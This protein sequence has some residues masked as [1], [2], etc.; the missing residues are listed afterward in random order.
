ML[1]FPGKRSRSSE[2]PGF[3]CANQAE[4]SLCKCGVFETFHGPVHP[5]RYQTRFAETKSD[6]E[7][8]KWRDDNV[9]EIALQARSSGLGVE[10]EGLRA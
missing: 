6:D 3:E 7:Y 4:P 10:A 9:K 2:D 1:N 8:F 5:P